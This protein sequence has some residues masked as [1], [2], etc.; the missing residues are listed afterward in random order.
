MPKLSY[1]EIARVEERR[2]ARATAA[3]VACAEP[4]AGG[5]M[6]FDGEGS[7][8]NFAV[9]LG[10]DGPV[11]GAEI[12]RVVGFYTTRGA[13][14]RIV[15]CPF[16]HPSLVR[17][18]AERGFALL[19]FVN[20]LAREIEPD[21]DLRAL[22]PNGWPKGLEVVRVDP[23][24]EAQVRLFI[25]V[26]TSGFRPEGAPIAP[27]LLEVS[28][29]VVAYPRCDSFLALV[30]GEPAGAGSVEVHPDGA[31]L[32][33]VSVLPR[34]R[35]RGIQQALIVRR[36]ERAR[37]LGCLLACI[38]ASPGIPT[39]R[40]AMRLGFFMAYS[41]GILARRSEGSPGSR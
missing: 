26:S 19:E 35:E 30:D 15:V 41:K 28:R 23:G 5:C 17:G 13:E 6:T 24:D 39:E 20:V 12:D 2:L 7:W 34:F 25:D 14:P 11:S 1:A 37:E 21:E 27:A 36:L 3:V 8:A 4:V 10:L 33:G 29:R 9:G 40:N 18:L 16:A 38:S 32:F 22:V 31:A